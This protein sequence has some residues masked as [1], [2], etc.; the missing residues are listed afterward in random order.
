MTNEYGFA[1]DNTLAYEIVL[2]TG[3]FK[4]VTQDSDPDLFFA[5][6]ANISSSSVLHDLLTIYRRVV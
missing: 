2:P 1:I 5:L 6:Q 4:T 3:V